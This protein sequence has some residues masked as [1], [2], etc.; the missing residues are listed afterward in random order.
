MQK[1]RLIGYAAIMLINH[2]TREF[3]SKKILEIPYF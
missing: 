1:M 3:S 2:Q